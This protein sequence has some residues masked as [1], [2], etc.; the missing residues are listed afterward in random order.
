MYDRKGHRYDGKCNSE[1]WKQIGKNILEKFQI[2][3]SS[4]YLPKKLERKTIR[5][6]F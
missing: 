2:F 1:T 6:H 4:L 3:F 5:R